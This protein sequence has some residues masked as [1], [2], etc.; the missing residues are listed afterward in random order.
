MRVA[1]LLLLV[2][3]TTAPVSAQLARATRTDDFSRIL[4]ITAH[5]DD[6]SLIAPLLGQYCGTT[7]TCKLLVMTRGENGDCMLAQGCDDESLADRRSAELTVAAAMLHTELEAWSLPDVFAN[8][9]DNWGGSDAV[10]SR[11]SIAV[12]AFN[13]TAIITFDAAHGTT[14]HPAHRAVARLVA[15]AAGAHR[16]Y[17]IETRARVN[18]DDTFVLTR[19]V[20]GASRL[21][22][23]DVSA[24]WH[25]IGDDMHVHASQFT[26]EAVQS[27]LRVNDR[28]LV[29]MPL[30]ATAAYDVPCD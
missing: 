20:D 5:P 10:V 29:L 4:A 17:Q 12:E 27:V 1:L 18:D 19:A 15:A 14:C 30:G 25:F 24:S 6:E 28:T 23:F 3:L 11:L 2:A 9:E 13:P 22:F 7:S 16:V 26:E 21:L 8:V